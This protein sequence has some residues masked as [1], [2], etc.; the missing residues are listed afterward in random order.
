MAVNAGTVKVPIEFEVDP[1]TYE[2]A[3]EA[4]RNLAETVEAAVTAHVARL[5]ALAAAVTKAY[6]EEP[7]PAVLEVTASIPEAAGGRLAPISADVVHGW[8][9]GDREGDQGDG[10]QFHLDD[11]GTVSLES[12]VGQALG[13]ASTCWEGGTNGVFQEDRVRKAQ[14]AL[15]ARISEEVARAG[16]EG[17]S[18]GRQVQREAMSPARVRETADDVPHVVVEG[19]RMT[20][21]QHD[22]A[23]RPLEMVIRQAFDELAA[24]A[25]PS[26]RYR[27][28]AFERAGRIVRG[29]RILA[30]VIPQAGLIHGEA[31]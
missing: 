10:F 25:F 29:R 26:E 18:R 28:R 31:E 8:L 6:G 1:A 4:L 21:A 5:D 23:R 15:E 17:F 13:F 30:S 27:E 14:R 19:V 11:D 12:A 16:M 7:A 3:N 2:K 24:P 22:A 20:K 9:E